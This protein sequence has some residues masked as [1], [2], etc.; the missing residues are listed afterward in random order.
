MVRRSF[1]VI[2]IIMFLLGTGCVKE[3]YDMNKLSKEAHISPT[4]GL[5]A[6]KGDISIKDIV[7]AND[8]LQFDE[9]N[10]VKLVFRKDSV[11][12]LT[13]ADFTDYPKG[14]YGQM[15]A[16]LDNDSIDLE[17][18]DFLNHLEGDLL[19][20]NA[21][22]KLNYINS[23][24]D[25][26][27][28]TL[29][30]TGK[31]NT[32]TQDLNLLPFIID[33]P[34]DTISPEI[35]STF[36]IDRN[37]SSLAELISLPPDKIMISGN[38]IMNPS[39]KSQEFTSFTGTR[40]L[41]GSLEIEVPLEFRMNNLSFTDSTENFLAEAFDKGDDLNWEDFELFR[42]DFDIQN[43]F[44]L[45]V[46]LKLS[47]LDSTTNNV[48]SSIDATDIIKPA[49]VDLNGKATGVTASSTSVLFTQQFFN[50]IN[51]AE[52]I[53]FRFTLNTSEN[54]SKDVKI[55]S[56]YRINFKASLV[57]K[58]DYKFNW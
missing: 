31:R 49:P 44:P 9:N 46:S 54:G 42:I 3:T 12:N 15:I 34:A 24:I 35:S 53:E 25:T 5:A 6:V 21:L 48:L 56:D 27:Q 1:P 55:Y 20:S 45:G 58:P 33:R 32:T 41:L 26:I 10:L 51:S 17:I 19:I 13:I 29:N 40:K 16:T 52:K 38:A 7:K 22:I 11:I 43:G 2:C 14:L 57:L 39:A 50:S 23:L 36:I 4:I 8:T 37:N 30:A 47:L 28:V 18:T